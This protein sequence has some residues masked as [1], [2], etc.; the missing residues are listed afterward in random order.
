ME[1]IILRNKPLV[2]AIYEFRWKL[3]E[4]DHGVKI[5]PHYKILIG[6]IYDKVAKEYPYHEQLP[7]ATF[8]DE[9]AGYIVQHRFRKG[10]EQWP[11]IQIGPGIITLND[12]EGYVWED[13][14]KRM[15]NLLD[16][17]F[18]AYP[19]A[20]T[21]LKFN[22]VLLRYIDAIDYNY[23][24]DN[25]FTFLKEN[26]K[27]NIEIYEKLFKE[28]GVRKLPL[29]FDLRFSFPAIKP[30]GEVHLRFVQGKRKDVDALIWETQVQLIN[31]DVSKDKK[32]IV[33][34]VKDA[35]KLTDDWF[36]K[37]IEGNLL[38]RFK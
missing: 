37:M 16:I 23:E 15:C 1:R 29:S 9:I 14:E 34:W 7:T 26:L 3:Q 12:T 22:R 10:K 21:N 17:L 24:K 20:E 28:T 33:M 2:E 30:K 27:I 18:E 6:R 19:D 36:F 4:Q 38:K 25:I 11:L 13:F 5:D 8:P 35:H 32:E 31:D